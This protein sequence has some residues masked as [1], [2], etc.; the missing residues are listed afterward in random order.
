MQLANGEPLLLLT[1]GELGSRG[2]LSFNA[3]A[4]CAVSMCFRDV[5]G[6]IER[7]YTTEATL[8]ATAEAV[9]A[10]EAREIEAS[11]RGEGSGG[12]I[13]PVPATFLMFSA[14]VVGVLGTG[15]ALVG[16]PPLE[17]VRKVYNKRFQGHSPSRWPGPRRK[18][19]RE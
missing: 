19:K 3:F 15:V 18:E 16:D 9:T 5:E 11:I 4:L 10:F 6:E 14:L 1:A 2:E 12:K 8:A 17:K 13:R 7:T